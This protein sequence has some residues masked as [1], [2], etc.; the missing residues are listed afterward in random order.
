MQCAYLIFKIVK[1]PQFYG[2][3]LNGCGVTFLV[4]SMIVSNNLFYCK[5]LKSR[6]W[7]GGWTAAMKFCSKIGMSA[8][9]VYNEQKQGCLYDVLSIRFVCGICEVEIQLNKYI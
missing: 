5:I 6:Q 2:K 4:T 9:T 7:Q 8:L 1:E 3:W